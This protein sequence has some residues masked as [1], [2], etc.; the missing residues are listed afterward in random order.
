MAQAERHARNT[1]PVIREVQA[2]GARSLA[3]IADALNARGVPTARDRSWAPM[4]VK[5]VLDRA[6]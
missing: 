2:R 3:E 4:T 5:R 6:G 1:L